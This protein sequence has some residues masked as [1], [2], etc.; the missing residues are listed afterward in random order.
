MDISAQIHF[1]LLLQFNKGHSELLKYSRP[2]IST[3]IFDPNSQR[4]YDV[5]KI[6][7]ETFITG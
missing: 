6:H 2:N 7:L 5:R 1:H 4:V 3:H